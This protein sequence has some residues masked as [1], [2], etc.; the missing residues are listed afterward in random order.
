MNLDFQ[1]QILCLKKLHDF[2]AVEA[3]VK[4]GD[5]DSMQKTID[6]AI[7]IL[8]EFLPKDLEF[9]IEGE[10]AVFEAVYLMAELKKLLKGNRIQIKNAEGEMTIKEYEAIVRRIE[11]GDANAVKDSLQFVSKILLSIWSNVSLGA[12]D[13]D[14]DAAYCLSDRLL[15]AVNS[16]KIVVSAGCKKS[17]NGKNRKRG[18]Q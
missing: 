11:A 16:G 14:V 7:D 8:A 4:N 10:G 17:A 9:L 13:Q 6:H 3:G 2:D 12:Y 18:E 5:P 15:E 1:T